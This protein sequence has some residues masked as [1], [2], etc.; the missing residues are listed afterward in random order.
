MDFGRIKFKFKKSIF[1][2]IRSNNLI[3]NSLNKSELAFIF[4][5]KIH[6]ILVFQIFGSEIVQNPFEKPRKRFKT[7]QNGEKSI[8]NDRNRSKSIKN[9]RK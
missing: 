1:K 6:A 3:K 8:E 4:R 7:S 9:G 2:L 5:T